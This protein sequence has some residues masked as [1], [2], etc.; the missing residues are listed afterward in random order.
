MNA[1]AGNGADPLPE[2]RRPGG[3][4][5]NE[6]LL[7]Q[8]SNGIGREQKVMGFPAQRLSETQDVT[9]V[10]D[11]GRL[12]RTIAVGCQV[13]SSRIRTPPEEMSSV[14]TSGLV[15]SDDAR[16]GIYSDR[17]AGQFQYHGSDAILEYSCHRL[18]I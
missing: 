7:R 1:C 11:G 8:P 14:V 12:R 5:G 13:E 3:R 16:S 15:E 17:I 10:V 6:C 9:A 18:T 4:R 2:G